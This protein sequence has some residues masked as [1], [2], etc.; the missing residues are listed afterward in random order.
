[1]KL[2]S[3]FKY[4]VLIAIL[5]I[6]LLVFGQDVP[7]PITYDE[8]IN[9]FVQSLG[10]F[11]GAGVLGTAVLVAQ[12]ALKLLQTGVGQL[13]GKWKLTVVGLITLIVGV[14]GLKATGANWGAALLNSSTLVAFQALFH[15]I[16]K[17][18]MEKKD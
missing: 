6:P 11:K 2:I 7:A 16:Y 9:F 14:L 10:G 17:Q 3:C 1:M 12:I 15:Q 4:S 18:F 8:F 5:C 13:L